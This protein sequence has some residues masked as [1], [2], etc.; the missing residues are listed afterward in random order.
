MKK[1]SGIAAASII[2][3]AQA[4]AGRGGPPPPPP[5]LEPG[6]SQ[7]DVDTA[8]LAAPG[9]LKDQATVIKWQPDQT[10]TTLRKGNHSR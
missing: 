6:A 4:P 3:F 10:Y 8:L 7:A 5:P 1:V 9:N 2:A